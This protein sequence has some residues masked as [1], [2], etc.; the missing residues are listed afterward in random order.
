MAEPTEPEYLD[1]PCIHPETSPA[2]RYNRCDELWIVT[3]YFNSLNFRTRR[4]TY[5]QFA[6][7]IRASGLNLFT[8]ECAFGDTDFT[9]PHE[10]QGMRL[11]GRNLMWQKERLINLAIAALPKSVRKVAWLDCDVMFSNPDWAVQTAALLDDCPIVQTFKTAIRLPRGDTSYRGLGEVWNGFAWVS[12]V[13]QGVL[14]REY[15]KHG[16]TGFGWAA[17]RELL[18]R[19]GLYDA[20]ISGSGDHFMA[21]A[22][23]GDLLMD[24]GLRAIGAKL[25]THYQRWAQPFHADVRGRIG[26]T[27]GTLLHL[28]HG[29][30]KDRRYGDRQ[31]ELNRLD[32]D[33]TAD[34]QI[35]DNGLWEWAGERPELRQWMRRYF[36]SRKEDGDG[37]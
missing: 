13:V 36:E 15:P 20:C 30:T 21:H 16:H 24:C 9:L 19:H 35:S 6:D 7:S 26:S 22:M 18:D 1:R 37:N 2:R 3:C 8:V 5:D 10:S 11:R 14:V 4:E 31:E 17:R 12:E 28:W 27:P 23:R 32:F 34:L 29:D 25:R 33:P